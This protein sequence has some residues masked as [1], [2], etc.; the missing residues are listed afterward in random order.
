MDTHSVPKG[1]RIALEEAGKAAAE[2]EIPVGAVV[3]RGREVLSAAHNEREGSGDPTAHA[4]MLAIR[5]AAKNAGTRRLSGCTLYVTLEPC[6]MCAG[7]AMAAGLSEIVFGAWD[8]AAGCA[9]SVY[10]LPEDPALSRMGAARC[11]GGIA[12][13][14]CAKLMRD[15]FQERRVK[16][17]ISGRQEDS[18]FL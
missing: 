1:M 6:A 9:G 15:F 5:R 8:N 7:A 2:H 11:V 4:E 3:M 12:E 16:E 13:E 14:P 17:K 10:A 18:G